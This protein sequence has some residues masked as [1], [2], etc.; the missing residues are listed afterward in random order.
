MKKFILV[1]AVATFAL[2]MTSCK[3]DYTCDCSYTSGGQTYTSSS[4]IKN[5]KKSD[6]KTAC[7]A[8]QIGG[9][10]CTLK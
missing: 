5:A 3:K 2:G 8:L 10:T 4:T 1:A 9:Y 7:T 6:A